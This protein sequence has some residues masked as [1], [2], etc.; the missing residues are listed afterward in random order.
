MR[1]IF[2][3]A[4]LLGGHAATPLVLHNAPSLPIRDGQRMGVDTL[5][6]S[7][8]IRQTWAAGKRTTYCI[9]SYAVWPRFYFLR[10]MTPAKDAQCPGKT[11]MFVQG[12]CTKEVRPK[13]K[14]LFVIVQCGQNTFRLY[15]RNQPVIL[16]L[17]A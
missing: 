2:L 4:L 17:A 15:F 7:P 5:L 12:S 11:P 8:W 1:S 10:H 3:A 9:S 6:A 13:G 16:Q 14:P